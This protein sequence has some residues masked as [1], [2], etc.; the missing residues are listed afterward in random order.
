MKQSTLLDVDWI[1]LGP[2]V[3]SARVEAVQ[4]D[5]SRPGT[6]YVA[7]G[8]GNLWKT[9]NNGLSWRPI[10]EDQ[11]A[12]GIGDIALSPSHPDIL[13]VGT[14]E[15][16]KKPRNFTMPG[17][18]IYRSDDGGDSWRHL[19]LEDSWHIGEIAIH[20]Y[21]PDIVVVAVLGHFWTP[22]AN[23]GLYL[24]E[25]GGQSWEQVLYLD[26]FTGA[27]DIVF[28]PS[29][30]HI[31]YASLWENYPN[32]MGKN[33]GVYRSDDGGKSWSRSSNGLP[34]SKYTGRIGLA[35]SYTNPDKVYALVD[36][37]KRNR[38][39]QGA[40]EVYQSLNGGQQ[41]KRTHSEELMIFSS[42]GWY[43]ADLYVNPQDDEE[44]FALGVRLGHSQD[45]G[46][47]FETI[48]GKVSHINPSIADGLHLDH[49]EMWINPD[50]PAHILLGNDGGLY[51]SYDTGE[52][53]THYNNLP[54]G[55]FYDIAVDTQ[56]PYRIYGGTQDDAT[57]YGPS[58]EWEAHF[59]DPWKY[60]W[61]D[62]WMGG[63][64]CMTFVDPTD[65]NTVYFSMQ[66]GA[67]RRKNMQL[68]ASVSIRP[69]LPRGHN[70]QLSFNF[71][72]PYLL[73]SHDPHTL[74]KAGNY[75]FKSIDRGDHWQVISDDLAVSNDPMKQSLAA[76]SLAESPL[77]AG[78][79]YVGTDKGACWVSEDDGIRWEERSDGLPV[80][81]IR[82]IC[83]SGF[84]DQRVYL[85]ST[86]I[87]YDDLNAYLFRS[88]DRGQQWE[89]IRTNLPNEPVNVILEDPIYPEILYA[90]LYRGVYVSMDQGTSWQ[91][92]GRNMPAVAIGDLA[93]QLPSKDLIV[94]THG[95]G[96][97]KINLGP[98]HQ[99]F[100]QGLS[101]AQDQLF[102][103]S[104]ICRPWFND[105]HQDPNYRTLERLPISFWLNEPQDVLLKVVNESW[106]DQW[107]IV[108]EGQEGLNQ[109][110]WDL[111][112]ER[113][114]SHSPY[115][116]HYDRF[117]PEGEYRMLLLTGEEVYEQA[118][119][120]LPGKKPVSHR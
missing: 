95:R 82:S 48:G 21:D 79:L 74:Y 11:P 15:S 102:P 81:Y 35:V 29:D 51:Q 9:T 59:P 63:D 65:P 104:D 96:I 72:S 61:I 103:L 91:L 67:V 17:T 8:S 47:T 113:Q 73:S 6:M 68:D 3:N 50:N 99:V 52:H 111:V 28:S 93:I 108:L 118:F 16:L 49:C 53:W 4:A 105:T 86:G 85:A 69:R 88:D 87:N 23:R 57:V 106:K 107:E 34:S 119:S 41:W 37:R 38:R 101:Y 13:Y 27:N 5:P 120:V 24:T 75:V 30:P 33:S 80:G 19:G 70:G 100:D 26:D 71:I 32:V 10:F 89:S 90:G 54:T 58:I 42:I 114:N 2:V 22:N 77:Q 92:L 31:L 46:R 97:Y 112:M 83:P 55:E 40:A 110:R 84:S 39:N 98:I 43:F 94:G 45:G 60:L 20:P 116:I 56:I 117:L 36:N 109:Y 62:A 1:S 115:F 14:G 78:L 44:I 66:E 7:F 25:D 76:A 12:L 18:G 64:G